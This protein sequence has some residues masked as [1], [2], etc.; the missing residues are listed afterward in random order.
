M[1]QFALKWI[2]MHEAVSCAIPG[3]KNIRQAEDNF[4]A[5]DLPDLDGETMHKLKGLY[6]AKIA[7]YVH[8][9]W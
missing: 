4:S 6:Q 8:Q 3:A 1:A 2:L 9:R 7:P 5:S